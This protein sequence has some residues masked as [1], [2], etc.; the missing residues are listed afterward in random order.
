[1]AGKKILRENIFGGKFFFWREKKFGGNFLFGGKNKFWYML[2]L[3][4]GNLVILFNRRDIFKNKQYKM[5]L[6]QKGS[7]KRV[8]LQ[9][10]LENLQF[11]SHSITCLF[12]SKFQDDKKKKK[13]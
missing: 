9:I 13:T 2:L 3:N 4:E 11:L 7:K 6:L 8:V 1:L 12:F 10:S 5:V